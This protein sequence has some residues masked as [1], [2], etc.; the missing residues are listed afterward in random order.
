MRVQRFISELCILPNRASC[1]ENE[2]KSAKYIWSALRRLNI[3]ATIDQFKSQ[4]RMTG[5]L[6]TILSGFIAAIILSFYSPFSGFIFSLVALL[7]FWGHFSNRF[8]PVA[9]CFRRSTSW[10]VVGRMKEVSATHHIVISAHHDTARSGPLWNP[11]RVQHFRLNFLLGFVLLLVLILLLLVK[12]ILPA[13][14]FLNILL[15]VFIAY[16]VIQIFMLFF[17][18]YFSP[19]VQ[20][21]SDNASGVA[22]VLDLAHK[23]A[24]S[25]LQN[26]NVWLVTTGSEEVG[27]VGMKAFIDQYLT[28]LTSHKTYFINFDNVG[29][30]RLHYY[31]GEGMLNLTRFSDEL[32]KLAQEVATQETFKTVTPSTYRLAYTDAIV[33]ANRKF[34]TLLFLATDEHDMIPHWHW[35]TDI[36]E[37]VN[38]GTIEMASAFAFELLTK[39]DKK[40]KAE[41][42]A[43]AIE[44]MKQES[45]KTE[46]EAE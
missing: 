20:G 19:L 30:D 4:K 18:G 22:V 24:E 27:A 11:A 38:F 46:E 36:F 16:S 44:R 42:D 28:E 23:L 15:F 43:A 26:I 12:I 6:I 1:S 33:P 29:G 14:L 8:K 35:T 34:P 31:L 41:K 39:L 10:N 13:S 17:S 37:N 2:L 45:I 7:L 32:I 21:A 3:D 40:V 5:E 25:P 9:R